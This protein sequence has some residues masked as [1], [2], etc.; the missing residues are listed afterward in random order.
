MPEWINLTF[1]KFVSYVRKCWDWFFW[2][3]VCIHDDCHGDHN[4]FLMI[5]IFLAFLSISDF[6]ACFPY[7]EIWVNLKN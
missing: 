6:Q 5:S 7:K 2:M 3:S 1:S 4:V